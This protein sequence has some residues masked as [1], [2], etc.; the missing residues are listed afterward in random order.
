M[1]KAYSLLTD[2]Q[3]VMVGM[4]SDLESKRQVTRETAK[5]K[6]LLLGAELFEVN[7]HNHHSVAL[8]FRHIATCVTGTPSPPAPSQQASAATTKSSRSHRQ[9]NSEPDSEPQ[10]GWLGWMADA[11]KAAIK[12]A[13]AL[14]VAC[15]YPAWLCTPQDTQTPSSTGPVEMRAM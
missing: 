6:A 3:F 8:P 5:L 1:V 14:V 4:K 2:V 12:G 13:S 9:T 11:T 7:V 10:Q 15:V